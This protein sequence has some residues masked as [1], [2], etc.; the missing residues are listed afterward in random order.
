MIVEGI[1]KV[2]S[3]TG[4]FYEFDYKEVYCFDEHLDINTQRCKVTLSS[5]QTI[6]LKENVCSFER[7]LRAREYI[8]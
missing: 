3:V 2:Q 8:R 4:V 7:R 6:I 5:G 1:I